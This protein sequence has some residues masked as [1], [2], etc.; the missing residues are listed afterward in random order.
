MKIIPINNGYYQYK[1]IDKQMFKSCIEPYTYGGFRGNADVLEYDNKTYLIGAGTPNTSLDKTSSE[2]TK[3]LILN[4]LSRFMKE[5][6]KEN[7]KIV[8]TAPPL[9]YESQKEELSEYLAGNYKLIHNDILKEINIETIKIFPET[10]CAFL[11]NEPNKYENKILLLVDIGGYTTNICKITNGN[12]TS[13]DYITVQKGM[14]FLDNEITK[15]INSKYHQNIQDEDMIYY[16]QD[17]LYIDDDN[18]N[19]LVTEHVNIEDIY[20][21]FLSEIMEKCREKSWSV[22]AYNSIILGGG[23]LTL[24]NIIKNNFLPKAKLSN[25]PIFDNLNG[26]SLLA[27]KVY[28]NDFTSLRR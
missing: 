26:L 8:L 27:K 28:Q 3:I 12:F 15:L 17:G 11:A 18:E 14:Y 21:Q 19:L 6:T 1:S 20:L 4:M 25:D 9:V 10:F 13:S 5:A 2:D 16:R 24:F 22:K 23:G 7:F